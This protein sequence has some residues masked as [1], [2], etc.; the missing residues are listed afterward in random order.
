ML[1]RLFGWGQPVALSNFDAALPREELIR[2]GALHSL[3]TKS[4]C[5]STT[6]GNP[7]FQL[8]TTRPGRNFKTMTPSFT[9]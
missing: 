3:T 8:T 5:S 2:M 9:M 7:S 4:L 1:K 6:F